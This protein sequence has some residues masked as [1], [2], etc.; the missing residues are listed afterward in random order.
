MDPAALDDPSVKNILLDVDYVGDVAQAYV[1]GILVHDNFANGETW[2]IGLHELRDQ[3]AAGKALTLKI[4]PLKQGV[5]IDV[6]S[7]MAARQ[8][9]VDK[10]IGELSGVRVSVIYE[11]QL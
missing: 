7:P 3:L 1:D 11:Y 6:D 4:T 8:E 5:V 2:R 9:H 10:E